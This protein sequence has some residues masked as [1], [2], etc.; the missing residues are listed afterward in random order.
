MTK[1]VRER[2]E[3]RRSRVAAPRPMEVRVL[4]ATAGEPESRGAATVAAAIAKRYHAPVLALGVV[5]PFPHNLSTITSMR[6]PVALDETSRLEVLEAVRQAVH[7]FSAG[8]WETRAVIGDP[9]S[10][11]D[12]LARQWGAT[13][14][15]T[16]LGRHKRVDRI[17]GSETAIAVMKH[18]TIP[19][20]A[21]PARMSGLPERAVAAIDFTAPSMAAAAIGADILSDAGTLTAVHVCG[22]AGVKAE[23]G[24]LV[25]LYRA[26]ASTKLELALSDL[27]RHTKR[28][29]DSAMLEGEPSRPVVE[30]ARREHCELITLGGDERGLLDQHRA[31]ERENA[32]RSRCAM[33]GI[34]RARACRSVDVDF[35]SDGITS[36]RRVSARPRCGHRLP[37]TR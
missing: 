18:S 12:D 21:V 31:G 3:T 34:G 36:A 37:S 35:R 27:R 1:T 26:G 17:F 28:R 13:L 19:V 14:I 11:I 16:G 4:L 6:H 24:D 7:Q 30:Y 25:E 15:V 20:L 8:E 32:R 9:A 10:T 33:R 23:P 22:F 29:V 2:A 5:T